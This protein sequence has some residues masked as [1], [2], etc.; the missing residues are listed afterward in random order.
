[1]IR[2]SYG[3]ACMCFYLNNPWIGVIHIQPKHLKFIWLWKTPFHFQFMSTELFISFDSRTLGDISLFSWRHYFFLRHENLSKTSAYN[4]K[5]R[6]RIFLLYIFRIKFLP[7][8]PHKLTK[9]TLIH[10]S[11]ARWPFKKITDS[12]TNVQRN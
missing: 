10:Y 11:R 12:V 5:R 3:L 2:F 4:R 6:A 9:L 8:H 7:E 1:M